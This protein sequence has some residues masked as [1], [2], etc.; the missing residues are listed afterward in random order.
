[1]IGITI[2]SG[3]WIIINSLKTRQLEFI[4][5]S[6]S[7]DLSTA[8]VASPINKVTGMWRFKK[9]IIIFLGDS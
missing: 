3:W 5:I 1:M 7:Y 6:R 2:E 8:V 9:E 4:A